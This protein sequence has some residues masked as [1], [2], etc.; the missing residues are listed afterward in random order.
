MIKGVIA[1][2]ALLVYAINA[3][4]AGLFMSEPHSAI[5]LAC[6]VFSTLVSIF[7]TIQYVELNYD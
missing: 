7:V 3:V 2:L 6:L 5:L 1:C 4:E